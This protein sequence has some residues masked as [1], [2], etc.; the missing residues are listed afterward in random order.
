VVARIARARQEKER[1]ALSHNGW[2]NPEGLDSFDCTL[3]NL[4][5]VVLG[6]LT[7]AGAR[8]VV[9][10]GA[11]NGL[12]TRELLAWAARNDAERVLAIDPDPRPLLSELDEERSELELIREPSHGALAN[13]EPTDAVILDGDHNYFTVAGE[14]RLIAEAAA[15]GDLPLILL[16]D[17]G[18]PLGRRD[19]YHDPSSLPSEAV[20]QGS[21]PGFLDP[22]EAGLAERGLYYRCVAPTEGGGENG[23]L[24]AVDDFVAGREEIRFARVPQF[25]GLGVLWSTSAPYADKLATFIGPW[26]AHPMLER[27]EA[28]RVE[29][30]VSEFQHLQ[31]IDAMRSQDY[32]LQ[33]LLATMLQSSALGIAERI[34]RLRQGGQ[35]LFTREQIEAALARAREDNDLLEPHLRPEG[36]GSQARQRA[37]AA[38]EPE[39]ASG[40]A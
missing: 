29:H 8:T 26:D 30:L 17:I 19:S 21:G 11:E 34:S 32:E 33:N 16:H 36:V 22:A 5:E 1:I 24:T 20:Q 7:A 40:T 27:A 3:A 25:F 38:D 13:L 14:L 31:Q 18:W 9:E 6:C 15:G 4:A 2:T 35:P 12:F 10:V 23:V 39:L 28:K 37:Q